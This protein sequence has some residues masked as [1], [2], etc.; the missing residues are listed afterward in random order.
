MSSRPPMRRLI[1][2]V[3]VLAVAGCSG[4]N[5]TITDETP[6]LDN[7]VPSGTEPQTRIESAAA[8]CGVSSDLISGNTITLNT[9]GENSV[10]VDAFTCYLK[11]TSIPDA[12]VDDIKGIDNATERSGHAEW[13]NYEADW[14]YNSDGLT[15]TITDTEASG[16]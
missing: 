3:M 4:G 5:D 11:A 1:V 15:I 8:A 14:K 13:D 16:S 2:L 6:W 12:P 7:A 10:A 9:T